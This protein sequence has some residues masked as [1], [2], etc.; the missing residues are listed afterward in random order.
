[1][2]AD[3]KKLKEATSG[4]VPA[5]RQ[6]AVNSRDTF[7]GGEIVSGAR[8]VRKRAIV[9]ESSEGEED[10]D[11]D[12]E[13]EEEQD[14]SEE[15]EDAE[16]EDD[17]DVEGQDDDEEMVDDEEDAE[18]DEDDMM[19]DALPV[20]PRGRPLPNPQVTVT[21]AKP[22]LSVEEKEMAMDDD[23]DDE[24][25]S[26][27]DEDEELL[28][29]AEDELG[30]GAAEG[31]E[32]MEDESDEGISRSVTPDLSKLTR[33]QRAEPGELMALSNGSCFSFSLICP[34]NNDVAF[35]MAYMLTQ[36][37]STEAQK[38]KHLTADEIT[39]RRAEM[40]RR[41]KALSEKRNDEEK[42]DTINRLLKRQA[43]KR[44]RKADVEADRIAEEGEDEYAR[45]SK[46]YTRYVQNAQGAMMGVPREWVDAGYLG[47]VFSKEGAKTTGG[48]WSGRM[49]EV[50][51]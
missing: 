32:E 7:I 26:E 18:G 1:V 22:L 38:K 8:S 25:L 34:R 43:S 27:L 40:A 30:L 49:V 11:D 28:E 16:G 20:P 19:D 24:E 44:Q 39:L 3:P 23:D 42:Q 9:E 41:R 17:E 47:G 48:R 50:V 31:D 37:I 33:R 10:D 21:P 35:A 45:P 14:D 29:G 51:E 15:E 13:E 36:S 46:I 2:K 5:K 4:S 12:E 6:A